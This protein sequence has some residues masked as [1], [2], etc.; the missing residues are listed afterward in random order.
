MLTL[1]ASLFGHGAIAHAQQ[2]S[3]RV[4]V[5]FITWHG[6]SESAQVDPLRDGLGELGWVDGRNLELEAHFAGGSEERA[7]QALRSMIERKF[8]VLVVRATN[9]AHFAKEATS[10]IPIVMLVSDPL[11]SGLV[12]SLARPEANLTGL[13]LQGPDLAGKR[14]EHLHSI[15]PNLRTVAFLGDSTDKNVENF[16]RETKAAADQIGVALRVHLVPGIGAFSE[17]DFTHLA[18][19]GVQAVLVQTI[20]TGNRDRM[21]AYAVRHKLPLISDQPAFAKAGALLTLGPDPV[22]ITRRASYFV[23][24]LLKGTHPGK[25]PVEQPTRFTLALNLAT[26]KALGL[27]VP[28]SLTSLADIVYE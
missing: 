14:L 16:V 22:A 15:M 25:L 1:S 11:A 17:Q 18:S 4:R 19:Q 7:R 9:V 28:A 5:G 3:A 23:D 6:P 20:F 2:R 13:S 21:V 8:D 27:R 12:R 26:A 10:T 24:R